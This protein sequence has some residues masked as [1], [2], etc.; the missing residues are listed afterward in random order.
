MRPGDEFNF[1][2]SVTDTEG[3]QLSSHVVRWAVKTGT[4]HA[5]VGA[6]G[7]VKIASG[8][9]EGEIELV[10]TLGPKSVPVA[11]QVVSRERYDAL[12]S[13]ADF[14]LKEESGASHSLTVASST[15][16]AGTAIADNRAGDRKLLF[17][18]LSACLALLLGTIGFVTLG[19]GRYA[20]QVRA[21]KVSDLPPHTS[22]KRRGPDPA[23]SD[24]APKV[25]SRCGTLYSGSAQFCGK[26]GTVLSPAH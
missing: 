22:R 19:R 23:A 7:L 13:S 1:S 21:L 14:N 24:S 2:A 11:V 25:C 17:V 18:S 12:L 15:I 8:A 20:R 16:G 26:D 3:C 5:Q 10:A 6:G 4:P 9:P